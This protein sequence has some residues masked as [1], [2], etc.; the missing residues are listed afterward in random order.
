MNDALRRLLWGKCVLVIQDQLV[1]DTNSECDYRCRT[2]PLHFSWASCLNLSVSPVPTHEL[3]ESASYNSYTEHHSS[4]SYETTTFV[5]DSVSVE[6]RA[7]Q[8]FSRW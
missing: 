2:L 8:T 5:H 4:S 3:A 6:S 7:G 1:S